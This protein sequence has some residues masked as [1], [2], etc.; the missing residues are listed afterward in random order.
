MI[1]GVSNLAKDIKSHLSH[2]ESLQLTGTYS[3]RYLLESCRS[4]EEL[5]IQVTVLFSHLKMRDAYL[6]KLHSHVPLA[7]RKDLRVSPLIGEFIF[8]VELVS[9]AWSR[10]QGDV[11][12]KSNT[13]MLDTLSKGQDQRTWLPP[14]PKRPAPA[15]PPPVSNKRPKQNPPWAEVGV[16]LKAKAISP[17]NPPKREKAVERKGRDVHD[18]RT[19]ACM[20]APEVPPL[21]VRILDQSPEKIAERLS[22]SPGA[23]SEIGADCRPLGYAHRT[24]GVQDPLCN[25][26]PTETSGTGD[27]IPQGVLKV[28]ISEPVRAR[29]AETRERSSQLHSPQAFTVA[30]S[31]LQRQQGSGGRSQI[32]PPSMSSCIARTSL[33]RRLG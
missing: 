8:D 19:L 6:S 5:E 33:W 9:Q 11:S 20:K 27:H 12:L 23:W 22:K 24:M 15:L 7:T 4:M 21:L 18:V 1:A 32:Y 25:A 28:V 3:Q 14:Q 16:I 13:I 2:N 10:L 30:C 31:F 17:G 26:A 29:A